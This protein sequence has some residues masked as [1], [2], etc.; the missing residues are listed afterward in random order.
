MPHGLTQGELRGGYNGKLYDSEKILFDD[1]EW[2]CIEAYFKLNSLNM[3]NDQPNNDGIVRG[4]FDGEMV[5]D[6]TDVILRSTDFPNM[7]IN[8]FLM[9]PHFG[10]GLIDNDQKLWIDEMAVGRSKINCLPLTIKN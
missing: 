6:H 5:V 3:G 9:A 8:Q 1:N 7:E 4:W 2:H 10:P